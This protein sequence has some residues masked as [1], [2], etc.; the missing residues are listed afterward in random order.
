MSEPWG[1]AGAYCICSSAAEIRTGFALVFLVAIYEVGVEHDAM[2]PRF[3]IGARDKTVE[4]GAG[5]S[6]GILYEIFGI[7]AVLGQLQGDPQPPGGR[8]LCSPKATESPCG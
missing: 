3:Q 7:L 5:T 2:Q 8:L 1:L 4:A 6:N